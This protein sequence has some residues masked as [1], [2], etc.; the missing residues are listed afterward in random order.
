M[1]LF[2][3]FGFRLFIDGVRE[4]IISE[5]VKDNSS[6]S[7]FISTLDFDESFGT[8]K[9]FKEDDEFFLNGFSSL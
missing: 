3:V 1:T 8:G 2:F 5:G 4:G 6:F 9:S 7:F